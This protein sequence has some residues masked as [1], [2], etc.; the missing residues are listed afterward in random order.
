[1]SAERRPSDD[2]VADPPRLR[3]RVDDPAAP[4]DLAVPAGSVVLLPDDERLVRWLAGEDRDR[5]VR[6]TLDGRR[7]D[8]RAADA[9]VRRGLAVVRGTDVADDVAVLDHLAS[10]C[11]RRRACE[12]LA[13][14]PL[15]A[16]RGQ[17]PAGVLSGGER[18]V[19][20]WLLAAAVAPRAVVLD[21]AGTGLDRSSLDWAHRRVDTWVDAGAAVLVRPGRPEER[22]WASCRADGRPRASRGHEG[23]PAPRV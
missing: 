13:S 17:D 3:L 18:R 21:R 6:L 2:A 15:L 9:R 11:G 7:I 5:R 12:L 1:V 19:L 23:P 20:G 14:S 10:A 4:V 16:H 8:R 22:A